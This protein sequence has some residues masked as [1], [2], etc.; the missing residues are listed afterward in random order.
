MKKPF[1][2]RSTFKWTVI[3]T[4]LALGLWWLHNPLEVGMEAAA[5]A[6]KFVYQQF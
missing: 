2:I 6:V 4:A 5:S 3:Y 1:N